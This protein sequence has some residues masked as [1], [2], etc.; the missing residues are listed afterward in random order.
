MKQPTA[1][2]SGRFPLLQSIPTND[3]RTTVIDSHCCYTRTTTASGYDMVG[4]DGGVFVFGLAGG[5]FG[6]LPG[7]SIHVSNVVGMVKSSDG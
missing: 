2:L 3:N 7:L 1:T 4:S 5:F 6:S